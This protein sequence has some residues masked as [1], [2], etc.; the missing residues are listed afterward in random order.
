MAGGFG[1]A[2]PKGGRRPRRERSDLPMRFRPLVYELQQVFSYSMI[3]VGGYS[4]TDELIG[5]WL[6]QL[7]LCCGNN[8]PGYTRL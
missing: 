4:Y 5:V 2:V 8:D 7:V 6:L 3:G 1:P